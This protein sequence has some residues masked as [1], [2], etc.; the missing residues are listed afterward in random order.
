MLN[1]P[2]VITCSINTNPWS[3]S[4]WHNACAWIRPY[5]VDKPEWLSSGRGNPAMR[6]LTRP[7]VPSSPL[8][9]NQQLTVDCNGK[10]SFFL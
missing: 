4:L 8:Q 5:N 2:I 3:C 1:L 6:H 10:L 9:S 7:S